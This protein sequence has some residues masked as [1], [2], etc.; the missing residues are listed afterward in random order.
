MRE[1]MAQHHQTTTTSSESQ[2]QQPHSPLS[3][4][5]DDGIVGGVANT[6]VNKKRLDGI[7]AHFH[8]G[9]KSPGKN[10]YYQAE[11]SYCAKKFNCAKPTLCTSVYP[12]V[13]Q[14]VAAARLPTV[15]TKGGIAPPI[16]Q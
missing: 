9:E 11:C 5:G 6:A 8:R 2:H 12:Q 7:S 15:V 16:L 4:A 13:A 14:E 3:A 1:E 10:G